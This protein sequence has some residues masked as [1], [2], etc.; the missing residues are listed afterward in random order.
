MRTPRRPPES[1]EG[2]DGERTCTSQPD[3]PAQGCRVRELPVQVLGCAGDP[4]VA[5]TLAGERVHRKVHEPPSCTETQPCHPA[6]PCQAI[7]PPTSRSHPGCNRTGTY[8]NHPP[9]RPGL[10][11][12][13]RLNVRSGSIAGPT[14]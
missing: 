2:G 8:A 1:S 14:P 11:S 12:P 10:T 6:P 13:N 7:Q 5:D 4:G 3:P 9:Q